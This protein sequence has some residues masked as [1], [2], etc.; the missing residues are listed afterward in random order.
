M[1]KNQAH[2]KEFEIQINKMKQELETSVSF[3]N[4][5]ALKQ[6]VHKIISSFAAL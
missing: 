2:N 3:H 5:E 4:W 1:E 6:L